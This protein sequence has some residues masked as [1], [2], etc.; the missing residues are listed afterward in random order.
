MLGLRVFLSGATKSD[1]IT[2]IYR[3]LNEK[4][5]LSFRRQDSKSSIFIF[6]HISVHIFVA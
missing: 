4:V 5:V 1:L 3:T 2:F 6:P